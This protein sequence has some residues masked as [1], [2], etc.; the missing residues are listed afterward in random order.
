MY[1]RLFRQLIRLW[2]FY[3][4]RFR[5]EPA[6]LVAI[7]PNKQTNVIISLLILHYLILFQLFYI[8]GAVVMHKCGGG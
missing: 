2:V 3:W 8:L 4:R 7:H 5:D 1:T 6:G